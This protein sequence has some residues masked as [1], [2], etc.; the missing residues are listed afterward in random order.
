MSWILDWRNAWI[1]AWHIYCQ[2]LTIVQNMRRH[3]LSIYR[4]SLCHSLST[5]SPVYLVVSKTE[6]FQVSRDL[7]LAWSA[8]LFFRDWR[9]FHVFHLFMFFIF[10]MFFMFFIWILTDLDRFSNFNSF[11]FRAKYPR[12][13]KEPN[14]RWTTASDHHQYQGTLACWLGLLAYYQPYDGKKDRLW[15]LFPLFNLFN[16]FN[17]QNS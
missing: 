1:L 8:F 14:L 11:F 10:F 17:I 5:G 4:E 7:N 2:Y 16:L 12:N 15:S 13:W 9:S 3:S 6:V